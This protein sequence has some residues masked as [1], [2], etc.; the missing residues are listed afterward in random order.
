VRPRFLAL[1]FLG[2]PLACSD[3]GAPAGAES[4]ATGSAPTEG[5]AGSGSAPATSDGMDETGADATSSADGSDG[6]GPGNLDACGA[7]PGQLFGPSMPWNTPIDDAPVD[8]ESE[9]IIAFLQANVQSDATFQ[10]DFSITVLEAEPGT[11]RQ[12]FEPT[13]DFY[14]PDCDPAPVPIPAGGHIEGEAGYTCD[15][16][17]DCHLIVIDR[18]ECRLYEQWRASY[19]GPGDYQGGCLA[20]WDLD[21]G[22]DETL[23]G[24][25]CTSADAAG[26]PIAA[27][28]FDADEVAA[29][30]IPHALRFILPNDAFRDL[31]YVRPAT[32]STSATSGPAD[33]PPY[34]ARL[35]LRADYDTSALPPAAAVVAEALKTYGMIASDGGNVTFTA[36][37]DDFTTA[38]WADVGLDPMD[39]EVLDWTDFEVV[40]GGERIDW[41]SGSCERTPIAD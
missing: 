33:A 3:D 13:G 29:G 11:M 14:D 12:P 21:V 39:L 10:I 16:D 27:H 41:N 2:L 25:F 4:G 26:L 18:A 19:A 31:V 40:D 36:E 15:G 23:R 24:D 30:E 34:G 17:G 20:V 5:G 28:L 35:R 8:P 9:A 22:Y 38:K 32:H 1:V 7:S 37:S 6:P